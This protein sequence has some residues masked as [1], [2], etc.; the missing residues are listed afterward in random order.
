MTHDLRAPR[1]TADRLRARR[2]GRARS[3]IALALVAA[4]VATSTIAPPSR[5][6]A[7]P[8][9]AAERRARASELTEQ[10]LA[11]YAAGDGLRALAAFEAA[12]QLVPENELLLNLGL[13]AELAGRA[14]DAVDYLERFLAVAS[15]DPRAPEVQR[16]IA[17][18]REQLAAAEARRRDQDAARQAELERAAA[19]ALRRDREF[20]ERQERER[21]GGVTVDGV[22]R[23]DRE[24][25]GRGLRVG[26][27]A[28]GGA[29]VVALGAGVYFGLEARR[30][31]DELSRHN[32]P[33]DPAKVADGEAADRNLVISLVAG[34]ALLGA[35]ATLY[36]LGRRARA[37]ARVIAVPTA[38]GVEV[39]WVG[40]F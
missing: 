15:R 11:A 33:Y 13:A 29:G 17:A 8:A 18:L 40:R 39:G 24:R 14:P 2:P 6:F 26:G 37:R 32:A 16:R 3:P 30:L 31:S 35:G 23:D 12:Y 7:Q 10:G 5:A 22:R 20:R 4:L 21:A 25:A 36:V 28:L 9:G 34:G 27:L 1:A 19:E 38:G